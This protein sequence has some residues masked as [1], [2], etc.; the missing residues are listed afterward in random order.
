[1]HLTENILGLKMKWIFLWY[2]IWNAGKIW[3]REKG[4]KLKAKYDYLFNNNPS[5]V[6]FGYDYQSSTN[7]RDSSGIRNFKH[8]IQGLWI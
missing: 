8:T 1:M 7:K 5:E 4:L 6:I 3:R 2:K